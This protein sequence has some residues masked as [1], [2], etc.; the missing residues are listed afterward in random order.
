[1]RHPRLAL[2]ALGLSAAT[3]AAEPYGDWRVIRSQPAPWLTDGAAAPT[4]LAPGDH[5]QLT[6]TGID[7]PGGL[8]CGAG[9]GTAL[10]VPAEGLFQGG[11]S[12]AA[13]QAA[14]LGFGAGPH[15]TLRIDC[16]RG[17]WDFHAAD[18][19]TLLFAY[20]Q[21][22]YTLSR[23]PGTRA[24]PGSPAAQVQA[25][26]EAHYAGGLA[27]TR[28]G[29]QA[30]RAW[31]SDEL[32]RD[33]GDYLAV[34]WPTDEVPPLNGD[35]YTN[36]QETPPASTSATPSSTAT[37]PASPSTSPTPT[38][39]KAWSTSCNALPDAGCCGTSPGTRGASRRCCGSGRGD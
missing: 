18:P 10:D 3:L 22:V 30:L 34:A 6:P 14:E 7:G 21:R 17:S 16:D 32:Y 4:H 8:R 11:L 36:S 39:S 23:S 28:E 26:L 15:P 1:M 35:P 13:A 2:L 20:D 19:D 9:Q 31:L 37:R 5:V 27:F 29:T 33:I 24:D 12:H 25:L 38:A